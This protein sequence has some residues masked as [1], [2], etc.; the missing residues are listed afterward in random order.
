MNTGRI[1]VWGDSLTFGINDTEEGGWVNRLRDY[2][3]NE[4]EEDIIVYNL[5][6]LGDNTEKLLN[7]FEIEC[8]VREPEVVIFAIGLNDSQYI[9]TIEYPRVTLKNFTKN[10]QKLINIAKK[11]TDKIGFIGLTRVDVTRTR[12][13]AW[14]DTKNYENEV[15]RKY[16]SQLKITVS[17]NGVK[18]L[19]M[20]DL[21]ENSDLSDGLHP[22]S[23]GHEKMYVRIKDFI[24][25][26]LMGGDKNDR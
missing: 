14:D 7:R 23:N 18:Y 3:N 17:S 2:T 11:F 10:I 9:N 4:I 12:P 13:L 20:L 5:G 1:C 16:D 25:D 21:L 19:Y 15:I 8:K 22:N 24:F 6:I 26:E